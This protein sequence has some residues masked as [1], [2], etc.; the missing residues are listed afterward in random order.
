MS[1]ERSF[2]ER[3]Y[4]REKIIELGIS[5][6]EKSLFFP[7]ILKRSLKPIPQEVELAYEQYEAKIR[8]IYGFDHLKDDYLFHGTGRYHYRS[9]GNHKYGSSTQGEIVDVLRDIMI[10]GLQ[11]QTDVWI[12]TPANEPTVSLTPQRF[13][14]RW[15]AERHNQEELL[16]SYGDP[17][18][19]AF[20]FNVRSITNLLEIPYIYLLI[21]TQRDKR[22]GLL[23]SAKSWVSDTR[24]DVNDKTSY[25]DV[26]RSKSTIPNNFG[27]IIVVRKTEVPTYDFPL[28]RRAEQRTM[29]AIP[30][31]N[32]VAIEV[33]LRKVGEVRDG[34]N[35]LG[36]T[37][38]DVLPIECVDLHMQRFPL[39]KLVDMNHPNRVKK[40]H[41]KDQEIEELD[42]SPI[43]Y[44]QIIKAASD[45]PLH[46]YSPYK[47][48]SCMD[49]SPILQS[50]LS[51]KSSWEG[52]TIRYHILSGLFLFEK[53]F[54]H[55]SN[56]PGG[57]S[58]EFFRIFFALHDIGDSLGGSVRDK[59]RKNREICIAFLSALGFESREIRIARALL[60]D[61]PIGKYL[62]RMGILVEGIG[63]FFQSIQV[64]LGDL[65]K[66]KIKQE[67]KEAKKEIKDMANIAQVDYQEFLELLKLFHIVDAGA[68]TSEGGTIGSLNYV[69]SFN[70]EEGKMSYSANISVLMEL[71]N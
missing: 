5:A 67:A 3:A 47:L 43:T 54:K 31:T 2:M 26:W 56:L 17:A 23:D 68:Y 19:W 1:K 58:K 16:W 8:E 37:N 7:I 10:L 11:P 49:E 28:L 21:K 55:L 44:K 52:F 40:P 36:F 6:L 38:I 14:S 33:P 25:L 39:S 45:N 50:L 12:P 27:A 22:A 18:D 32:F 42:F 24:D 4:R 60:L 29:Q 34:L 59:L 62:K 70:K 65:L 48:V 51:Q 13:Y 63:H 64:F 57:V 53:Y 69:F 30:A 35:E 15:Y 41:L 61:D 9:K 66:E 71:L 20:L 46:S